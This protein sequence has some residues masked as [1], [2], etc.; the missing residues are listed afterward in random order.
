LSFV[1]DG[2]EEIGSA[3]SRSGGVGVE[4]DE[5]LTKTT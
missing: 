1:E 2:N 4:N 3:A 5:L